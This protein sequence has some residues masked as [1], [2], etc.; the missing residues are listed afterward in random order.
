MVD[1][2]QARVPKTR[3]RSLVAKA[4]AKRGRSQ[5]GRTEAEQKAHEASYACEALQGRDSSI[6]SQL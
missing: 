3:K 6:R 1:F 4:V 5:S 2:K